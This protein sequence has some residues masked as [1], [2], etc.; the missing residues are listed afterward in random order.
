MAE[1]YTVRSRSAAGDGLQQKSGRLRGCGWRTVLAVCVFCVSTQIFAQHDRQRDR[2]LF[3]PPNAGQPFARPQPHLGQ[4]FREHQNMTPAQQ[5]QALRQE[6][7]FDR[8]P[9]QMQARL[10]KRLYQLNAM[11]PAQ[12]ERTL[13]YMEAIEHMSPEQRQQL[14]QAMQ[15]VNEFPFNRQM[16]MRRAFRSLRELPKD[17]RLQALNSP[18]LLYQF[19]EPERRI[20]GQLLSVAPYLPPAAANAAKAGS[21]IAPGSSGDGR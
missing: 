16:Q 2:D 21:E 3:Q 15:R 8:L 20:L 18:P 17:Q 5:M 19:S 12:R 14:A 6:P 7:G 11:P 9:P 4:W 13:Q 10:E 1:L